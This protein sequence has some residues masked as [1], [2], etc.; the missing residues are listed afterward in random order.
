MAVDTFSGHEPLA[1][2]LLRHNGHAYGPPR[3]DLDTGQ[4]EQIP[5]QD[6]P[7]GKKEQT[8]TLTLGLLT[9]RRD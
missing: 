5:P 2:N 7:N 1:G 4:C 9:G 6:G 3:G 8:A